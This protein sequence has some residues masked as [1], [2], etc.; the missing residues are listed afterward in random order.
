MSNR[1]TFLIDGFNLYHSAKDAS[2]H[3]GLGGRGTKWLNIRAVCESF[4]PQLGRD[5][6][7]EG[8]HYFSALAIH[9]EQYHP[10]V[11]NRH[12][13]FIRCIED[14]GIKVHL[15]RFKPKQI[16]CPHCH[17]NILRYEEKET[18]VALASKMLQLLVSDSCD[19]IL[20]MTG[21]TDLAPAIKT[22]KSL[23]AGKSVG[24]IFPFK[25]KNNELARLAD[26]SYNLKPKA[27]L[28]HQFPDE[29]TLSD[30]IIVKKPE[31]W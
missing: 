12:K 3:L 6:T 13:L 30:G 27:Y 26:C 15:S 25:R 8:I 4:L 18:D 2:T 31:S 7:L 1:V 19:T 28:K 21:D 10:D 29:I 14:T 24:F 23:S 17:K 20:L 22:A 11:T 5:A 16:H 9:I